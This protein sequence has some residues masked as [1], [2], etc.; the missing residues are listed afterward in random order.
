VQTTVAAAPGSRANIDEL[1]KKVQERGDAIAGSFGSQ[2]EGIAKIVSWVVRSTFL[3][4]RIARA[5]VEDVN[6]TGAAILV[7]ALTA[8]PSIFFGGVLQMVVFPGG[9]LTRTLGMTIDMAATLLI[10]YLVL[11]TLSE[12]FA[13]LKLS[14][15]T[16]V[17]MLAYPQAICCAS[18]IP[19]LGGFLGPVARVWSLIA[20]AV[21]V[22]EVTGVKAEKAVLF[23]AI[24]ALIQAFVWMALSVVAARTVMFLRLG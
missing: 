10:T 2:P 16:L 7:L 14:P 9:T 18:A 19:I 11:G 5:A 21:A 23:A 15:A 1:Q 17:R 6:G 12:K 22:R 8:I 3:D 20:C 4:A 24:G 13:G